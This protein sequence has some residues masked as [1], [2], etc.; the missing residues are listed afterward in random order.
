MK[1]FEVNDEHFLPRAGAQGISKAR[2]RPKKSLLRNNAT[3]YLDLN[4]NLSPNQN[5]FGN[6]GYLKN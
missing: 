6:F 2:S 5:Y 4:Q 3:F 1:A